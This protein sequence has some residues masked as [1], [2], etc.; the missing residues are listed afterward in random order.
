MKASQTHYPSAIGALLFVIASLLLL[1]LSFILGISALFGYFNKGIPS[2]Q[3]TIYATSLFF[4]GALLG[5]V[6]I[7]SLLRHLNKPAAIASVSTFFGGWKIATGMFGTGLALLLGSIVQTISSINWLVLPLLTIPAVMLP[8]WTITGLGTRDLPFGS[9][10]RTWSII[11]ISM[12]VTPIIL[13]ILETLVVIVVVVLFVI[14]VMIN[15]DL[16]GQFQKLSPQLMY[17][18]LQ[19]EEAL[20]VFLPYL[21]KP[22]VVAPVVILF[23]LIVPLMEELIKPLAV[24]LLSGKLESAAQGF[25]FGALSGAGFAIVETFNVSG[26]EAGWSVLLFTRIGTGLLHITTSALMGAAIYLAIREQRYLRLLGTYLLAVFLHGLWNASAVTVS[27][28]A[29]MAASSQS[30][31]SESFQWVALI[32]LISLACVLFTILISTNRKLYEITPVNLPEEMPAPQNDAN[33]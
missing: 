28:S 21:L 27:F 18:D 7:V 29:L 9:R 22:V 10:W 30:H 31:N 32:T 2:A 16:A 13:F 24:W 15:P 4:M 26:Q 1:A 17:L 19:S 12:T 23:S 6:S 14:Y 3:S 5:V 20:R 25:A 8:I 11:G 33:I